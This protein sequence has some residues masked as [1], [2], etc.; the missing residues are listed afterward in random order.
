M[1]GRSSRPRCWYS[2]MIVSVSLD[3]D[4]AFLAPHGLVPTGDVDDGQSRHAEG[5]VIADIGPAVVGPTMVDDIEHG[6]DDV[7]GDV[8]RAEH[9]GNTAHAAWTSSAPAAT[10]T[11]QAGR[12][13]A[14]R[15]VLRGESA[16][17]V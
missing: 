6:T 17:V 11:G 10:L 14:L 16:W 3:A 8:G 7:G 9:T 5:E 13:R 12:A 1:P 4:G 2:R 15:H